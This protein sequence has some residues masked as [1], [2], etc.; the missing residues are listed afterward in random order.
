MRPQGHRAGTADLERV[1]RSLWGAVQDRRVNLLNPDDHRG[2][3][4]Q[5]GLPPST[6][7]VFQLPGRGLYRK[8]SMFLAYFY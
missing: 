6:G 7:V 2:A 1:S 5:Q 8:A 4:A 3:A